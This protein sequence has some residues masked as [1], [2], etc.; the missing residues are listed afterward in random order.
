MNKQFSWLIGFEP[1]NYAQPQ[2]VTISLPPES[3]QPV[4]GLS[5]LL[6]EIPFRTQEACEQILPTPGKRGGLRDGR[7]LPSTA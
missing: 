6:G 1:K 7:G 5:Y 3:M 2:S 4:I